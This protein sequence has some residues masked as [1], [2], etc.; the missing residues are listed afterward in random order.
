MVVSMIAHVRSDYNW[1]VLGRD[2][3]LEVIAYYPYVF[4]NTDTF[5]GAAVAAG[6]R[7]RDKVCGDKHGGIMFVGMGDG[8][9]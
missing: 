1:E 3:Y 6:T 9:G 2:Y 8:R 7:D 5:G 4:G